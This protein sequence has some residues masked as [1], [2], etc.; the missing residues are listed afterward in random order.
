MAMGSRRVIAVAAVL[1][2]SACSSNGP[3]A[4]V[5]TATIPVVLTPST[6]PLPTRVQRTTARTFCP[7]PLPAAPAGRGVARPD[8]TLVPIA[9]VTVDVCHYGESGRLRGRLTLRGADA[10][11]FENAANSLQGADPTVS[12]RCVPGPDASA[13]I[14]V[15]DGTSIE[16]LRVSDSGCGGVDNGVLSAAATPDWKATLHHLLALA[17]LCAQRFGTN[18]TCNAMSS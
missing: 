15:S 9:A 12:S 13:L 18:T 7:G 14:V 11:T 3:R 5:P 6:T 10:D 17:D 16:Q 8:M 4:A 1:F 2:V